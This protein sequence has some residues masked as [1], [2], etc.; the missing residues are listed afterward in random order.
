VIRTPEG[1]TV[2]LIHHRP[3]TGLQ[4][5]FSLEY[6]TA[7]TLLDRYPGFA[8][9]TDAAVQRPAARRL[10]AMV[11]T[12]LTPG[13]TWMLDGQLNAE[14]HTSAGEVLRVRQQFPPG[15]PARPP[16]ADDLRTKMADCVSGLVTDPQTWTWDNAAD[17]L[18]EHC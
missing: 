10:A 1:T 6:A 3:D 17:V 2:P 11:E 14:V 8:S 9:F 4:G 7:A 18:R 16:T 5:K 15:S 13:G 12:E